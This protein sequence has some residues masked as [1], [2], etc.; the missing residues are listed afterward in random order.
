ML[1]MYK[2]EEELENNL[3]QWVFYIKLFIFNIYLT[4]YI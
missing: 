3:M 2:R 1:N 4:I